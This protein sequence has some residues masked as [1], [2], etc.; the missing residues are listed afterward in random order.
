MTSLP[1]RVIANNETEDDFAPIINLDAFFL[2]ELD[3]C[4]YKILI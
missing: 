2:Q 4:K 1:D 3:D